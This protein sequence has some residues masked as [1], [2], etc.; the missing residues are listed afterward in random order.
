M[1]SATRHETDKRV[2]RTKKAIRSALFK[3]MEEKDIS[4]I[5]IIELTFAAN[6]NRRT[7]YTHY[8]C[9]T[10]I[11]DECESE[12]V[13]EIGEMVKRFNTN[14][15][16]AATGQL[17]LDFHNIVTNDFDYYFHLMKVDTRGVLLTRLKKVIRS[18]IEAVMSSETGNIR[19]NTLSSAFISGGLL[20]YYIEWYYSYQ[21]MVSI[22]Q[23]AQTA[24]TIVDA[25]V[26]ASLQ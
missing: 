14:D 1:R 19:L 16:S 18:Y 5:S 17:F 8:R 22:E 20:N 6:V 25:C 7:F 11:L 12:L 2:V 21:D 23:A 9:I 15:V 3:L 10:D 13:T 24:G 4:D 26:K